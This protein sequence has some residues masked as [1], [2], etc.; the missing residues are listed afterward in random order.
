M[1]NPINLGKEETLERG[2]DS[3]L[4]ECEACHTS[5]PRHLMFDFN[6]HMYCPGH[7]DLTGVSCQQH[8]A[9]SIECWEKVGHAC[10]NEHGRK[11][12][13]YLHAN[14]ANKI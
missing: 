12:L 9:C 2:S 1:L 11:I 6:C 10:V 3:P 14:I 4:Q 13:E 5:K 7:P 8:W